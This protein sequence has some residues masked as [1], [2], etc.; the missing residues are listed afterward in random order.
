MKRILL[1]FVL[2]TVFCAVGFVACFVYHDVTVVV[3]NAYAAEWSSHFVMEHLKSNNNQW[4]TGWNE[5]KDDYDKA[6]KSGHRP[7][8][9]WPELQERIA[10]DWHAD[11]EII[12]ENDGTIDPP[13]RVIW[14]TDGSNHHWQGFEPN[15]RIFDYLTTPTEIDNAD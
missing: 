12:A 11:P 9:T 8:T 1:L 14:L 15:R 6:V 13:F 2:G 7:A 4:P 3:P 5:L 10:I